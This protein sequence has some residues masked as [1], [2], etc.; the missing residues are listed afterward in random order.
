MRI[1]RNTNFADKSSAKIH[2]P[3]TWEFSSRAVPEG[4]NLEEP[5]TSVNVYEIEKCGYDW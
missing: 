5:I 3:S 1:R 4:I 2:L